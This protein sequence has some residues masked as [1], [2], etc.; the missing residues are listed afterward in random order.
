[1]W[2]RNFSHEKMRDG[3]MTTA[4]L[5]SWFCAAL[6]WC[7]SKT[8]V[9]VKQGQLVMKVLK[10]PAGHILHYYEKRPRNRVHCAEGGRT[11]TH[12]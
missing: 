1:M 6:H 3:D 5:H 12:L 11:C 4:L 9:C 10:V 7:L 2:R 8:Q